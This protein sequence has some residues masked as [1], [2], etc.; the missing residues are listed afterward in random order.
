MAS[1]ENRDESSLISEHQFKP[2]DTEKRSVIQQR[3]ALALAKARAVK[4]A[5]ADAAA[6]ERR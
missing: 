3:K 1:S 2:S 6:E 5:K 4:K